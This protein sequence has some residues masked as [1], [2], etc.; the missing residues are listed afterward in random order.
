[1][2]APLYPSIETKYEPHTYDYH[3]Y[4]FIPQAEMFT[5]KI[6]VTV[7]TP[8]YMTF[9]GHNEYT[10]TENGYSL[11]LDAVHVVS[12]YLTS[13]PNSIFFTLCEV[14]S[15]EEDKITEE[16]AFL[17]LLLIIFIVIVMFVRAV[18]E[19]IPFIIGSFFANL[20]SWIS[21]FINSL[22]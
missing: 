17:F 7:N 11:T 18:I 21:N 2:D 14:E 6:D 10:K 22:F 1:M 3:Y 9:N 12:E 15:P 5:G 8:Y 13:M 4:L 16:D 19:I 20:F